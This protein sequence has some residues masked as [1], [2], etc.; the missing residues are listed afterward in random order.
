M[1][2]RSIIIYKTTFYSKYKDAISEAPSR[3][4]LACS[5][6]AMETKEQYV[7]YF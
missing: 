2:L 3:R 7:K 6:L 5:K 1:L 4:P